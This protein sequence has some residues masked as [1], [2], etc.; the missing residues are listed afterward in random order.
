MGQAAQAGPT[1]FQTVSKIMQIRCLLPNVYFIVKE[2]N[3]DIRSRL[4]Y[5]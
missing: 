2:E 1:T 3:K 5:V 4:L